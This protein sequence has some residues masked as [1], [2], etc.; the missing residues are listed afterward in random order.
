MKVTITVDGETEEHDMDALVGGMTMQQ[1]CVLEDMLG[2]ERIALLF[3]GDTRVLML[4]KTIRAVLFVKLSDRFPDLALTD[5]D[6]D[7]SSDVKADD[8]ADDG[9]L[10]PM[11]LA[12][13]STV[14]GASV[15]ADPPRQEAG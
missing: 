5:F 14:E 8:A 7:L 3:E 10:L 9:V 4:P 1:A 12:D 13:G 11:T 15:H 6:F 2:E